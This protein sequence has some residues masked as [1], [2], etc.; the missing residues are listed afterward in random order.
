MYAYTPLCIH[1]HICLYIFVDGES[2][3]EVI[4]DDEKNDSDEYR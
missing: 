3:V 4:N 1:I 2:K